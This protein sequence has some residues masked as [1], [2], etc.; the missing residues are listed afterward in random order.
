MANPNI[1][2]ICSD[3]HSFRFTG[4]AGHPLVQ[5]PNLDA[6][7]DR[8][9]VFSSAYCGSPVCVPGRACMMTGMYPSDCNSFCNSTVWDGSYPTWGT[10]MGEAGYHCVATGK[11]DLNADRELGFECLEVTNGHA[12]NADITSLFRRPLLGFR[13]GQRSGMDGSTRTEPHKDKRYADIASGWIHEQSRQIDGP[14]LLYA[15]FSQPHPPFRCLPEHFD[16][17]PLDQIDLPD[18][19]DGEREQIHATYQLRRSNPSTSIPIPEENLRRMRAAYYGMI[20][21]L[22]DY[23]GQ[24][25]AALESTDQ[26]ENTIVLYTSDH[27]E[28][29]GEH[30]LWGKGNLLEDSAH[31]PLVLAGPGVPGGEQ[32]DTAVAH[33]DLVPTMLDLAGGQNPL[34]LRGHSLLP[35]ISGAEGD[36]PGFSY[37]ECH[38]GGNVTGTYLIR[39]G[40]WKYMHFTWFGDLLFNVSD[41]P[42]EK[43]NRVEDPDAAEVLERLRERLHSQVQP[44]AL[45]RRAFETQRDFLKAYVDT[46]TEDELAAAFE[47][48]MGAALARAMAVKCKTGSLG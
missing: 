36:H 29:L 10:L 42:M 3:Q 11:F 1:V 34:A 27:G 35:M 4:Y 40:D 20:T 21:E 38:A 33:V 5:S 19:T 28:S 30:D 46:R 48:R 31:I 26:L 8:G 41:D 43:L 44:E 18:V 17:Y 2:Y 45:T 6:L 15:G 22:D 9:T 32:I 37:T 47:S 14:W 13:Q 7:A 16:K 23:I 39:E 24:I 25:V 12:I